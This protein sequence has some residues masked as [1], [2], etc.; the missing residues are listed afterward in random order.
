MAFRTENALLCAPGM[1]LSELEGGGMIFDRNSGEYLPAEQVLLDPLRI[2]QIDILSE[3]HLGCLRWN[4]LDEDLAGIEASVSNDG[5]GD[6]EELGDGFDEFDSDLSAGF[7]NDEEELAALIASQEADMSSAHVI[8]GNGGHPVLGSC[9]GRH[10]D[11]C[12]EKN[13]NGPSYGHR[14]RQTNK[15]RQQ[16]QAALTKAKM[17]TVV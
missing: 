7:A 6:D 3:D 2:S 16:R 12:Q 1:I 14:G 13:D 17:K 5:D 4:V 10:P 8:R 11:F 15:G 9:K